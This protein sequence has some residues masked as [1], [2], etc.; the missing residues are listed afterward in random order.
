MA[1]FRPDKH[2]KSLRSVEW[3]QQKS[4]LQLPERTWK[5]AQSRCKPH[6]KQTHRKIL[7]SGISSTT[8]QECNG[9]SWRAAGTGHHRLA[10]CP[11]CHPWW[12][13]VC[14]VSRSVTSAKKEASK[15]GVISLRSWPDGRS[16]TR[17]AA[18][19]TRAMS[20][21]PRCAAGTARDCSC[22][23]C[24]SHRALPCYPYCSLFNYFKEK[25]MSCPEKKHSCTF[26]MAL[27][28]R[29]S[30]MAEVHQ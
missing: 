6:T 7:T 23:D 5:H 10:Y 17:P 21:P 27:R 3:T 2:V 19:W 26:H 24:D 13:R 8:H 1:I 14:W 16:Q 25:K 22:G 28:R 4:N 11:G 15:Q 29:T 18:S 12:S 20:A 9:Q 30:A